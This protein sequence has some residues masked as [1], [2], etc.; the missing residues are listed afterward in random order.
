MTYT[1]EE[2]YDGQWMNDKRH[3]KGT[4]TFP[5]GDTCK[6]EWTSQEK[7][8]ANDE[9]IDENGSPS[10]RPKVETSEGDKV[11]S[12]TNTTEQQTPPKRHFRA[13]SLI[14]P[15]AAQK[16]SQVLKRSHL[17]HLSVRGGK[18]GMNKKE[19]SVCSI[20]SCSAKDIASKENSSSN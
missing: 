16:I 4:M 9:G 6:V 10:K 17:T 13:K 11:S 12:Q 18:G 14:D 15:A 19:D 7:R 20:C 5:N 1:N 3:G 8:D 2:V